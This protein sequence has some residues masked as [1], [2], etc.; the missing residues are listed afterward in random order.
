MTTGAK[1]KDAVTDP[2]NKIRFRDLSLADGPRRKAVLD[3]VERVLSHGE[4]I[5]GREVEA[6]EAQLAGFSGTKFCV[7][8]GSGTSALY[9]ALKAL[10][11]GPGD[12]VITTPLSWVATLNAI[13]ATGA[14]PVFVDIGDD[15]NID[16]ALIE[17]ALTPCTKAVV[18]V[19]F[20]GRLCDM[21][22]I[23]DIAGGNGLVVVEDA[24]QALGAEMDG[25]MAGAFGE[26]GAFS[27]N[28]MKVFSG[29]GEAGAVV[30]DN[31]EAAERLRSLRYLGTVEGE[32]CV[33]PELNHK[34]DALQAAMLGVNFGAFSDWIDHRQALARR[35]ADRIGSLVACPPVA[36]D[37]KRR[38]VF[39]DFTIATEKRD[40]LRDHLDRQ[41]IETKIRHPVLMPDQPAFAHLPAYDLPKARH[42]VERI[43]CLP[44][45]EKLTTDDVDRVC[46]GIEEFFAA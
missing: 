14:T 39:F 2:A 31:E 5:M 4:L 28:P 11:V 30:T 29:F 6:F 43:L 17:A 44:I 13:H 10:G 18:P 22:R 25:K 45:H 40:Q 16:A 41:G 38:G 19:H 23:M 35:Y 26:A 1:E 8:V 15:L 37:G 20:T 46:Q 7:G 33:E 24:A 42:L 32:T 3:A 9:L 27:F 36:A 34:I 21:G 12:E